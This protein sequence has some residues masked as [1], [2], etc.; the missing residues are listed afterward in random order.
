M[1]TNFVMLKFQYPKVQLKESGIFHPHISY[2]A[3]QYPKVQLKVSKNGIYRAIREGISIPEGAI[4]R[5][6][7]IPLVA[8]LQPFQYPKVQL[9]DANMESTM[10]PSI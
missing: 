4:K 8:A 7:A 6:D 2:I 10:G 5:Q 9:K 3:F 1:R